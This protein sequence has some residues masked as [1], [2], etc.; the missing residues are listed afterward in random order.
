MSAPRLRFSL[1]HR[2]R[3]GEHVVQRADHYAAIAQAATEWLARWRA[4][5]LTVG[6]SHCRAWGVNAH[7]WRLVGPPP[8]Y[9]A[10]WLV[11]VDARR[12]LP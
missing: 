9:D 2:T 4:G 10:S 8:D 11:I 5:R 12:L 7:A 6:R 3:D 1:V